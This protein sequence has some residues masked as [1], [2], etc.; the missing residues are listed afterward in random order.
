M[1]TIPEPDRPPFRVLE[2]VVLTALAAFLRGGMLLSTIDTPGDGPVKALLAHEWASAPRLVLHGV[3]LPGYLYLTGLVSYFLPMWIA[4]R[5]FNAIVGTPTVPVIFMGVAQAF[6]PSTGLLAA[7]LV[8]VLP[9]HVELSASSLSEASAIFELLLGMALLTMAARSH[10]RRRAVLTG[11]AISALVLASA[12]RYEVWFLLPLFPG[13]YWLR[14]RDWV[15]ASAMAALLFAFP[16]AWT[17]GNH[18]YEGNALL[19]FGAAIHDRSFRGADVGV[20]LTRAANL[21]VTDFARHLGWVFVVLLVLGVFMECRSL[22]AG[23]LSPERI[24][25]L[26]VA[27]ALLAGTAAFTGLRGLTL[28]NRRLLIAFVFSM[29]IAARPM[30]ASWL[31]LKRRGVW[32]VIAVA[33]IYTLG[34]SPTGR[35]ESAWI[36]R[37]KPQRIIG[38]QEWIRNTSWRDQPLVFTRVD[39]EPTYLPYYFPAWATRLM[40]VSDWTADRF[41]SDWTHSQRPALLVTQ[42]GDEAYVERFVRVTGI[43]VERERLVHRLGDLEVYELATSHLTR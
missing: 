30:F 29:P 26:A 24:L 6:G 43:A 9:L 10:G 2:V 16:A 37:A 42:R 17:V 15:M 31:P 40:I 23:R 5:L 36:T 3:W 21:L 35:M 19:G 14:T 39:W 8:A 38:F 4:L 41:I 20:P 34:S 27:L 28:T 13:Y 25:Y 22:V 1:A 12:T 32:L 33:V 18:T 7:A 11:L